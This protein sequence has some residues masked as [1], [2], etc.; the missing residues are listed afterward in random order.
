MS[1]RK[2]KKPQTKRSWQTPAWLRVSEEARRRVLRWTALGVAGLVVVVGGG[3]GLYR[4]ERY[5]LGHARFRQPPVIEIVGAPPG[6]EGDILADLQVVAQASWSE[7]TL[8]RS[9]GRIVEANPWVRKVESVQKFADGRVV[10]HCDYRRPSALVQY[11]GLLYLVSQD[12]VRLPGTYAQDGGLMLIQGVAAAPPPAGE[13]W[14]APD[15]AAGMTVASRLVAEPFAGQITGV[16]VHNYGGRVDREEAHIRL[17][18]DRAGGT[19][20]WGSAPGEELEENTIAQKI[21][22]LRENFRRSGR[23]DADRHTID[24]ST[25]PHQFTTPA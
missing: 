16:L 13:K 23:V 2:R 14:H 21:A 18:T 5:A 10:V 9:I 17:A 25:H 11:N 20:I 3:L 7:N 24:I 6:V 12:Q 8:C 4:L 15:L 1:R 22:I 19:I